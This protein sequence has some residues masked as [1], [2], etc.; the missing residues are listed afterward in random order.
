MV[1]ILQ[2]YLIL[3]VTQVQRGLPTFKL[4]SSNIMFLMFGLLK[5]SIQEF[6]MHTKVL[7]FVPALHFDAADSQGN[8]SPDSVVAM[9][10]ALRDCHPFIASFEA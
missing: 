3:Y 2:K 10:A 7:L 8:I 1:E 6:C 5:K 9:S 4:V